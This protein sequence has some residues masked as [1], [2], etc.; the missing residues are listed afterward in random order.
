MYPGS[1]VLLVVFN[2][3]L[4]TRNVG[5]AVVADVVFCTGHRVGKDVGDVLAN[6]G[7]GEGGK[8]GHGVGGKVGIVTLL[9]FP[10]E[11]MARSTRVPV[12][13]VPNRD[14]TAKLKYDATFLAVVDT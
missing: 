1:S 5:R 4:R 8:V 14:A 13:S 10:N 6:V 7:R 11:T 2:V 3:G 9:K 12:L